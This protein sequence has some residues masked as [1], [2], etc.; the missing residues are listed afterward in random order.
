MTRPRAPFAKR[1]V[2]IA[3][4]VVA[5]VLVVGGAI[6][7]YQIHHLQSQVNQLQSQVTVLYQATLHNAKTK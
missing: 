2:W 1:T 6:A 4:A 3:V 7:G 5:V